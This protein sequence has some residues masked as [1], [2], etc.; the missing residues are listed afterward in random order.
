MSNWRLPFPVVFEP[1]G[2][3]TAAR[4]AMGLGPHRGCDYNGMD[5]KTKK[6]VYKFGK[7]TPLPAIADGKITANYWSDGLGWVVELG[8]QD[9]SAG[10]T[11]T[12]FFMYCHLDKQSPLKVGTHVKSGASVGGAGTSGK[13]S[14]G[15]HLHFTLSNTS[16]GGAVGK[17]YDAHAFLE[18]RIAGEAKKR[19]AAAKKPITAT[20]AQVCPT[21]K[22]VVK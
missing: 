18:K 22:Q 3:I 17:V 4:K 14:S 16:K 11:R 20:T 6:A 7:G 10:K 5:P 9:V 19:A 1:F 12:L 2:S 8:V 13:F 21:C 15:V